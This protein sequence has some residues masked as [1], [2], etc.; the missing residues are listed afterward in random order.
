MKIQHLL[1]T[2]IVGT[3]A[4]CGCDKNDTPYVASTGTYIVVA[5]PDGQLQEGADYILQAESLEEG[6]ITNKN[7]G[8]EQDGYRYYTFTNNRV[9]SLLYGQGNPGD[10]R[11]YGLDDKQELELKGTINTPTVQAFGPYN[12]ELIEIRSPRNIATP[13][14]EIMRIDTENYLIT[15]RN[16]AINT[17]TLVGNGEMAH[18]TGVFRVG[19]DIWAPF[20]SISGVT[21][22][23]FNTEYT[24]STWIAVFSYPDLQLKTV[25]K[26]NRTSYIGY[27]FAQSC[28]DVT[29]NGD[30]YCFSQATTGYNGVK[31]SSNPSAAIRVKQ[32]QTAFDPDYFFNIQAKSGGYHLYSAR[33]VGNNKFCLI[34]YAEP[35]TTT[36]AGD[37][38][39]RFA[40][41]DVATQS[42]TWVTGMPDAQNL[43]AV[44]RLPY[45]DKNAGTIAW[46]IMT[47]N[48]V[49]HVYIIDVQ[50]A[51][52][53]KGLR[54][55]AG[56][57]TAVGRIQ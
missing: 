38:P 23:S 22:K 39:Y 56:G 2:A 44:A 30:V 46:G 47:K 32:G 55:E 42:F 6:S 52:A 16:D 7:A 5:T 53:R 20:M 18:F 51:T 11:V 9:F 37:A 26:D 43:A 14:A 15:G 27:Y 49:P 40:I 1:F 28:L 34:M 12:K 41:A 24:D 50:T 17:A 19:N 33:Y 48:D 8:I 13:N 3:T 4:L 57:I 35:N 10:V 21:G 45:I 54:V 25:I 36:P 29:E 31:A